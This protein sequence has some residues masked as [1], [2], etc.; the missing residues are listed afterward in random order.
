MQN[1]NPPVLQCFAVVFTNK[2]AGLS[3]TSPIITLQTDQIRNLKEDLRSPTPTR[4]VMNDGAGR[5]S[6]SLM[7]KV[8]D[9]LGLQATPSAIQGRFGSAK[10][11][12]LVDPHDPGLEDWIETYPAQ[13]KWACDQGADAPAHRTLEVRSWSTELAPASL[14]VQFLPIL[15]DRAADAAGM[16]ATFVRNMVA[17][18]AAQVEA[19]KSCLQQPELFRKWIREGSSAQMSAQRLLGRAVPFLG[20]LPESQDDVMSFLADGG[21]DPLRLKFLQDLVFQRQRQKGEKM[22]EGLRINIA[23]STYAYMLVDFWGV[24]GPGEVHLS[25]SRFGDDDGAE[26]SDLDGVDVLVARAP[27]HL[28]SDIQKVKAVFRPELRHLRDVIIF[29]ARGEGPLAALLSGGDYD[30][31]KAWVCW[32]P[33]IVDNFENHPLPPQPDLSPYLRKDGATL[34]DLHREYGEH[35]YVDAMIHQAFYFNLQKKFLGK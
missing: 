4:E 8:R 17:E 33:E 14:N 16:R 15:E 10:G 32:D 12:W 35:R 34:D 9:V 23:R 5:I 3:K 31:D 25:F 22:K 26:L 19:L 18:S 27:A 6:P 20:G 21:F 13:R 29:S 7:R 30:G 2:N 28:P 1:E 24:L 11:M